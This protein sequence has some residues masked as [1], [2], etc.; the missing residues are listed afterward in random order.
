[1]VNVSSDLGSF[2]TV[3]NPERH[4]PHNS[5]FVYG[6]SKAVLTVQYAKAEPEIKFNAIEPGLTAADLTASLGG[7]RQSRRGPRSSSPRA[8]GRCA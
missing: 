1:V 5:V 2:W 7:G 8:D 4:E 6:A 3:T